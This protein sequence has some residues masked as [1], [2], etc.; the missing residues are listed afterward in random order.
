MKAY[1]LVMADSAGAAS[2]LYFIDRL[3]ANRYQKIL[4]WPWEG[5]GYFQAEGQQRR[6]LAD[7]KVRVEV[8]TLPGIHD[9]ELDWILWAKEGQLGYV[10]MLPGR[11]FDPGAW[12]AI[13]DHDLRDPIMAPKIAHAQ[14]ELEASGDTPL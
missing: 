8:V 1:R 12:R 2:P 6:A 10:P 14:R 3:E 11:C 4:F 9:A 7:A 13:S 5:L